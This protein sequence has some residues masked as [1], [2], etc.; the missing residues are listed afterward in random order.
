MSLSRTALQVG[1]A[2]P[3]TRTFV[4]PLTSVLMR[5][6]PASRS[7]GISSMPVASPRERIQAAVAPATSPGGAATKPIFLVVGSKRA[8]RRTNPI[9]SI[10]THILLLI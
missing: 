1:E 10:T 6:R 7:P 9:S 2:V 4:Q 5:V 3:A 8:P